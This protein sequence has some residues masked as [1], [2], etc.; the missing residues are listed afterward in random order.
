[1]QIG[2]VAKKSG[3]SVDGIRFYER[4]R[5]V[6]CTN[7]DHFKGWFP[8]SRQTRNQATIWRFIGRG[9]ENLVDY[10]LAGASFSVQP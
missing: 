9:P 1:M 5:C 10:P 4:L 3:L 8:R 2:I 6:S 7:D